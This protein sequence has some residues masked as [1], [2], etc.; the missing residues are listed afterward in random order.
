MALFLLLKE[1]M[2]DVETLLNSAC[3]ELELAVEL[4]DLFNEQIC[5]GVRGLT[6]GV[7]AGDALQ[8]AAVAHRLI[9]SS[10]ACG[11]DGLSKELRSIELGCLEKMP[12]DIEQQIKKLKQL[13]EDNH[14]EMSTILADGVG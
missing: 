1:G 2:I 12:D 14:M 13:F 11:F 7:S 3:D 6:D 4:L 10:V 9:G 5:E 8:V